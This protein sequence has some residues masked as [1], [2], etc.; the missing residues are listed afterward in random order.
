MHILLVFHKSQRP[1]EAQVAD[2]VG[3][4][5]LH[6]PANVILLGLTG[7]R[8]PMLVDDADPFLNTGIDTVFDSFDISAGVL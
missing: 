6:I 2:N 7:G 1:A 3:S 5:E 8:H 4:Q